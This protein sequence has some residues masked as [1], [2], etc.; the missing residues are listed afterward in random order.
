[1][2]LDQD[3]FLSAVNSSQRCQ[4]NWDLSK[5][6]DLETINWLI[7]V[8]YNTPT[9]QN[10]NSFDIVCIKDRDVIQQFANAAR[11]SDDELS[12][13]SKSLSSAIKQGR[14]QNPQTNSNILFLFFMREE[15]RDSS[16]KFYRDHGNALSKGSYRVLTSLEVGLSAGAIA[17]AANSLGLKSGFC[18]C[19][20]ED[21]FPKKVLK[22]HKLNRYN[23]LLMLGIGYPLYDTHTL[24]TDGI[25]TSNTYDKIGQRRII[26]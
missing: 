13:I 2:S 8:G 21:A 7:D 24:H 6:I 20:W 5:E 10:L 14:M 1:M 15:D 18:K 11:N 23:L 4:R 17:I 12:Q 22:A 16:T 25:N 19:F 3:E 26:I 9:K